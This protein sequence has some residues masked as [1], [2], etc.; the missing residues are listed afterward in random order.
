[1]TEDEHILND[2]AK[3]LS[4]KGE[5]FL[6]YREGRGVLGRFKSIRLAKGFDFALQK[7]KDTLV[8]FW[9]VHYTHDT[10]QLF[11]PTI[12]TEMLIKSAAEKLEVRRVD[13][14]THHIIIPR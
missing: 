10:D 11:A 14:K 8:E 2:I 6:V 1:M 4:E 7:P 13:S 9:C 5:K 12:G 3:R